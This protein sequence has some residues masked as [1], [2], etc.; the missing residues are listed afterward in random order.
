M[1]GILLRADGNSTKLVSANSNIIVSTNDAKEP[2][3]KRTAIEEQPV[4]RNT[5]EIE[6][7]TPAE[8]SDTKRKR[9]RDA[10]AI[11][12][13]P[14]LWTAMLVHIPPTEQK[15]K[16]TIAYMLKFSFSK[17]LND[18]HA[19]TDTIT[20]CFDTAAALLDSRCKAELT[21]RNILKALAPAV[22][23]ALTKINRKQEQLLSMEAIIVFA[24][25]KSHHARGLHIDYTDFLAKYPHF[26]APDIALEEKRA[27]HE[28]CNCTRIVQCLIPP[29]NNKEHILDLVTRLVEGYSVRRV[30]GTGMT[31]E[32]R[33]RYEILHREG[34]IIPKEREKRKKTPAQPDDAEEPSR[35]RTRSMG[36]AADY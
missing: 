3:D 25:M 36:A 15:V 24:Y 21:M 8:A 17:T 6:T 30:T 4:A 27:L 29:H 2:H 23:V 13:Q 35:R 22:G 32:T 28:F 34:N 11:I 33:R 19:W 16:D 1:S 12:L 9:S 10:T 18:D 7:A 5:D 31:A 26:D 20:Q 14:M